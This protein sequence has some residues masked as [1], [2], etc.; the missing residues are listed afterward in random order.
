MVGA[1]ALF[2]GVYSRIAA[3]AQAAPRHLATRTG[4]RRSGKRSTQSNQDQRATATKGKTGKACSCCH[5]VGL[6]TSPA[7]YGLAAGLLRKAG[8][9]VGVLGVPGNVRRSSRL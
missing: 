8:S 5:A 7:G 6:V 9:P 1:V 4:C 3:V 2:L